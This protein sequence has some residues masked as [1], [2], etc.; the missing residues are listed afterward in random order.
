MKFITPLKWLTAM[1]LI[2]MSTNSFAQLTKANIFDQ[3]TPITWLGIDFSQTKFIGAPTKG[4]TGNSGV[5][6]NDEFRLVFV[7]QWNQLFIDEMKKYDVAKA[8]DRASVKYAIDVT[9]KANA[10]LTKKDFFSNNPS[11]FKTLTDANIADLVKK[12]N[13]QNN[14]EGIGLMFI[15]EGMSKGMSSVGVWVTFIDLK[16]KTVLLTNYITEKP[17]GFGFRNYWAKPYAVIIKNMQDDFSKKW[18]K[19]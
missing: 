15:T 10:E 6:T 2:V 12:Y 8:T 3:K 7:P 11:D 17:G 19:L 4:I 16:T 14:N 1:F 13:F 18:S 5:V 9:M